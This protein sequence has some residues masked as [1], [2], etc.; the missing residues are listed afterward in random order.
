MKHP[1]IITSNGKP[2]NLLSKQSSLNQ[3]LIGKFLG[4]P[5]GIQQ[6]A[7]AMATPIRRSLDYH[8][9]ARRA[10]NV[11]PLPQGALP[12]YNRDID[13]SAF[14][15]DDITI[16]LHFKHDKLV[17]RSNG[18]AGKKFGRVMMPT[19]EVVQNPTIRISDVKQRRFNLIDRAAQ[20]AKQEIMSQE[21]DAIF[22]ALDNIASK[23]E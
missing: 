13:V 2:V 19:F 16:P 14:I 6:L 20:K 18:K 12:V 11:Q 9:I 15:L 5:A 1:L 7:Q 8:H 17:I 4:T 21:D 23:D 3:K 22:K 10:I